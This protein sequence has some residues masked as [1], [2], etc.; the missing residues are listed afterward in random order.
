M[1]SSQSA[2]VDKFRWVIEQY[3]ALLPEGQA[4]VDAALLALPRRPVSAESQLLPRRAVR[5]SPRITKL[6]DRRRSSG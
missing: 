4:A 5:R 2:S 3:D 6:F 1:A